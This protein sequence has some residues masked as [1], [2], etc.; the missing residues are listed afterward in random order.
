MQAGDGNAYLFRRAAQHAA[1]VC[2]QGERIFSQSERRNLQAVIA[3]RGRIG[4]LRLKR[5][6]GQDF[7]AERYS[8]E[9]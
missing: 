4:A 2:G 8:H 9:K 7:V 5:H 1:F 6:A 3:E